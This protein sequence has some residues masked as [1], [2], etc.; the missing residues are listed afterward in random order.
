M[1][2]D[3]PTSKPHIYGL[4][5]V[6]NVGS[7][8]NLSCE[9][10][11]SSPPPVLHWFLNGVRMSSKYPGSVTNMDPIYPLDNKRAISRSLLNFRLVDDLLPRL[12]SYYTGCPKKH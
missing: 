3:L 11:P 7:M 8:L 12:D 4:R 5:S 10:G 2:L 1:S 9:S 6:Y